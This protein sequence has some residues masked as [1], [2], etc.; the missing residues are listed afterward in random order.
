MIFLI[1]GRVRILIYSCLDLIFIFEF[2]IV[3]VGESFV[4]K[5]CNL[6]FREV[7]FLKIRGE[8]G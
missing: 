4:I 3:K 8:I 7:D 2:M 1:S 5:I 6:D